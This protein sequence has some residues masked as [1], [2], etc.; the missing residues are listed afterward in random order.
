LNAIAT[1]AHHHQF[2]IEQGSQSFSR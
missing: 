1:T 2:K